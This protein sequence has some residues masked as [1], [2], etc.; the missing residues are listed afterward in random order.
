MSQMCKKPD[1]DIPGI[2]CGY[3]LPCPHHTLIVNLSRK[4]LI[5]VINSKSLSRLKKIARILKKG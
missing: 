3:P 1:R 2:I 5:K 4:P